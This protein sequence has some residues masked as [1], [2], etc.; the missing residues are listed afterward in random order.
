MPCESMISWK[1]FPASCWLWKHFP[2]KKFRDAW[3][4]GS[5]LSEVRWIR[6]MRQNFV[7]QFVN[8]W[9][10][11]C[12]MQ[13]STVVEKN[14]ALSVDQCRLRVLQFSV[15]LID[16]LSILLR[17]NGFTR[18]QKALV[19]Q[20]GRRPPN[21]EHNLFL[22]QVWPWEVHWSFFSVQRLM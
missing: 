16:L 7:V 17:C 5:Q 12:D 13:L 11:L 18:I 14:W 21:S 9:S 8:F 20:T 15:Y 2:Y 3:R 22:V 19:D 10:M 1:A 4:S 6:W